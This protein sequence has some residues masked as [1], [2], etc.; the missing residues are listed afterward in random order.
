MS[1]QDCLTKIR[2]WEES[3]GH[4]LED[5]ERPDWGWAW[6]APPQYAEYRVEGQMRLDVL[7]RIDRPATDPCDVRLIQG[8]IEGGYSE[9]TVEHDYPIE[10]WVHEDRQ[11][12]KVWSSDYEWTEEAA[13]AAFLK[14]VTPVSTPPATHEPDPRDERAGADQEDA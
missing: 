4:E 5:P 9:Y 13:L 14:W 7:A 8:V 10:V 11:A 12:Q 6:P 3:E 2:E 1:E